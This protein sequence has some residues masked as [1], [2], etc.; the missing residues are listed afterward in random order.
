MTVTRSVRPTWG[1]ARPIP[2]AAYIVSNMSAISRRTSSVTTVTGLVSWRRIGAPRTW[3]SSRLTG[4]VP[5]GSAAGA[6]RGGLAGGRRRGAPGDDP[7][8]ASALDDEPGFA[9]LDGDAVVERW[10]AVRSRGLDKDDV[11]DDPAGRDDLVAFLH[12]EHQLFE[13]LLLLLLRAKKHE[14]EDRENGRVHQQLRRSGGIHGIMWGGR[15][16]A[17]I[18]PRPARCRGVRR[19]TESRPQWP[20]ALSGRATSGNLHCAGTEGAAPASRP[21]RTGAGCRRARN[22]CMSSSHIRRPAGPRHHG[23][24]PAAR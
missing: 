24:R 12:A 14:V 2:R 3:M 18:T 16:G 21:R 9:R 6:R 7:C 15:G 23:N 5:P 4:R 17:R 11:A 1:A 10:R 8:D 22:G 13:S 20:R 19:E